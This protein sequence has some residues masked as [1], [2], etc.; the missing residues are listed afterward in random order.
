MQPTTLGAAALRCSA[1][2]STAAAA[3]AAAAVGPLPLPPAAV[4]PLPLPVAAVAAVVAAASPGVAG[5]PAEA[6][7]CLLPPS[8]QR[9]SWHQGRPSPSAR[10]YGDDAD[11]PS[12][13]VGGACR[14]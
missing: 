12:P 11:H 5:R 3:A 8:P 4:G 9:D 14:P 6:C 7:R 13:R 2:A 10:V 1:A